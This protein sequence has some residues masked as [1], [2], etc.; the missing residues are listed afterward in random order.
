V[1]VALEA[2]VNMAMLY[3]ML[4]WHAEVRA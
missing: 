4:H 3:R 1:G 2:G